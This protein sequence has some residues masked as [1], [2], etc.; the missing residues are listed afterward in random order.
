MDRDVLQAMGRSGWNRGTVAHA[1]VILKRCYKYVLAAVDKRQVAIAAQSAWTID[2]MLRD[3]TA[4]MEANLLDYF[5]VV[6]ADH[7]P[8]AGSYSEYQLRET[9]VSQHWSPEGTMPKYRYMR[10]KR[11]DELTREQAHQVEELVFDRDGNHISYKLRDRKEARSTVAKHLGMVNDKIINNTVNLF[12]KGA[13]DLS[14][15]PEGTLEE[16]EKRLLEYARP[17]LKAEY[18]DISME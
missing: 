7:P 5:I 17:D 18:R 16:I 3:L 11:M 10:P 8:G 2:R 1:T 9:I 6:S 12:N 13:I 14:T 15:V 4:T